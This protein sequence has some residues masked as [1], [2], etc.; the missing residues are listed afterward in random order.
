LLDLL[1]GYAASTRRRW[2]ERHPE[3]RRRLRQAVISVGNLSV[4]GT[5]KTPLVTQIARWLLEQGHHPAILT[6]GYRR[7][8]AADGV[9]IVA[10]RN[11]V[12]VEIDRAGDEPLM[13]ARQLPGVVVCVAEDRHLA[14]VLA[15][16]VLGADVHVLDDGFQH[17]QLARDLDILLTGAGEITT[18]R[19]IPRGRLREPSA[20]AARAHYVVVVG[21]DRET[22][23]TEAWE[24]GVEAFSSAKRRLDVAA[25][26]GAMGVVAVA[27]IGQ[28]G[29]F[30]RML[31]ESGVALSASLAFP[32]HHSYSDKDI[33][34]IQSALETSA[35]R[36]VMTT[37]KDAVRFEA[38]GRLPFELMAVPMRLEV[39]DWA[40]LT[41]AL[42]HVVSE[43][44]HA[45]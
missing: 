24:L 3:A 21:T 20:A 8:V 38:L 4:G 11:S 37:E 28:P 14:G 36:V 39:D 40:G 32:D 44:R 30:F 22:A 19:V 26:R 2:Y 17:V 41:A 12:L 1:Y 43:R 31:E 34:R 15:E 16:R 33:R 18:G 9:T 29:Q 45:A 25:A 27:G 5:G 13:M 10:D 23:R 35:A 42:Q 6:R 7:R